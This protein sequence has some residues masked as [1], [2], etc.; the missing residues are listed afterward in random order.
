ML[1]TASKT[2]CGSLDVPAGLCHASSESPASPATASTVCPPSAG[3]GGKSGPFRHPGHRLLQ[4]D[5]EPQFRGACPGGRQSKPGFLSDRD[6]RDQHVDRQRLDLAVP[7]ADPT[8]VAR[9]AGLELDELLPR[10]LVLDVAPQDALIE[11][12]RDANPALFM[13]LI[14]ELDA[15]LGVL[16]LRR[17]GGLHRLEREPRGLVPR[18][19]LVLL[20]EHPLKILQPKAGHGHEVP[21]LIPE[22]DHRGADLFDGPRRGGRCRI[23]GR[24]RRGWAAKGGLRWS[25]GDA[26][27]ASGLVVGVGAAQRRHRALP[28]RAQTMASDNPA[29]NLCNARAPPATPE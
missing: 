1:P 6:Q 8:D 9:G 16:A 20:L 26:S 3:C 2:V 12:Q 28:P 24:L 11:S 22:V 18:G 15:Q 17:P 14:L 10:A 25:A 13:D 29:P 27:A 19:R 4:R 21:V 7:A 5:R 23:A